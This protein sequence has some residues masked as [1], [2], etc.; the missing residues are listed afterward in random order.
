[1]PACPNP[2]RESQSCA[3]ALQFAACD[4]EPV[5]A[6]RADPDQPPGYVPRPVTLLGQLSF[7]PTVPNVAR[8][9]DCLLGRCFL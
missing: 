6:T 7:D 3:P 9:Y 1:M 4:G 5:P 2:G 8:V